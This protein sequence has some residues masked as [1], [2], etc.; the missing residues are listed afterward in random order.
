MNFEKSH[1]SKSK[2]SIQNP[3]ENEDE[4]ELSGDEEE[5]PF[6]E[7]EKI[8]DRKLKSQREA[9]KNEESWIDNY[10]KGDDEEA[11]I[12]G[13]RVIPSERDQTIR[14]ENT[15]QDPDSKARMGMQFKKNNPS[16]RPIDLGEIGN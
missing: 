6:A 12:T 16:R 5:N 7:L 14:V 9:N 8:H 13:S 1:K 15:D 3:S 2:K 11:K 10:R 4:L